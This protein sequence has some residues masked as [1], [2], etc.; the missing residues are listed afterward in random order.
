MRS[1]CIFFKQFFY[2]LHPLLLNAR[3]GALLLFFLQ[4]TPRVFCRLGLLVTSAAMVVLVLVF[5][6]RSYVMQCATGRIHTIGGRKPPP[7]TLALRPFT[8]AL[9]R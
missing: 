4:T 3:K 7:H 1:I 8:R 5:S 2:V 6:V 9:L